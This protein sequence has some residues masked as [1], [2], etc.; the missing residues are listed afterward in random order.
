MFMLST[1]ELAEA[2]RV[3]VSTHNYNTFERFLPC[4]NVIRQ[5]RFVHVPSGNIRT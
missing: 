5:D 1:E 4:L 3:A 2:S